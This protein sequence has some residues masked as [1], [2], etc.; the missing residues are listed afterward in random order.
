MHTF[1]I[2][3]M[4]LPHFRLFFASLRVLQ[5]LFIYVMKIV[6]H[7]TLRMSAALCYD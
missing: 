7:N 4:I 6:L 1:R 3:I 2:G 5:K